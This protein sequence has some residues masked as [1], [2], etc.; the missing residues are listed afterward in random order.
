MSG[1]IPYDAFTKAAMRLVIRWALERAVGGM[2]EEHHFFI[3]FRTGFPGVELPAHVREAYPEQIQIVLKQ[4]FW[5]L[6]V[7][8]D[9]FSVGLSFQQ[10]P[11]RIVVPYEAITQFVDPHVDFGLRFEGPSSLSSPAEESRDGGG[12]SGGDVVSLEAFRNRHD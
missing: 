11:S 3:S 10:Q 4:H 6:E 9:R 5:D 8:E 7:S 2:P 12:A 1:A